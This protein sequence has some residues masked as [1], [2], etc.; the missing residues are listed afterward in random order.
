MLDKTTCETATDALEKARAL[1]PMIEASAA[2]IEASRQVTPEMMVALHEAQLFRMLLPRT[3]GGLELDIPAFTRVV[4]EI[5]KADASTA[6]VVGQ[7]CGCSFAAAFFEPQTAHEI[8]DRPDAILAW[9]PSNRNARAVKVDG[10]YRVS[11]QWVFASG[12]RYAQWLGAHCTLSNADGTSVLGENGQPVERSVLFPKSSAT[13]TDVWDVMGLKGTGSDNYEVTDL[14]IPDA[15]GFTRDLI[16]ERRED[17]LLYRFSFLNI[18]GAA[19]AGVALGVSRSMLDGFYALAQ[20]KTPNQAAS[21]LANNTAIQR[22]TGFNEA[23]WQAG[24][25]YLYDAWQNAWDDVAAR[26][27]EC[28]PE[29]KVSLRMT[30]TYAI[31]SAK[32]AGE[33]AYQSAGSTAI[34]QDKPFERRFRDIHCVTQ[35]GQS[36]YTNYEPAGRMMLGLGAAPRRG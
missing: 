9:G 25:A 34:F 7:G 21:S 14:F 17:G 2:D 8:F 22:E 12:S 11:G 23:K 31:H 30:S 19:F 32:E 16:P 18:Y 4:E 26:K 24:R 10:G 1:R 35:Q 29:Q 27:G 20:K 6:W 15:Y 13:V 5:A 3:Y 33:W 36:F 28:T